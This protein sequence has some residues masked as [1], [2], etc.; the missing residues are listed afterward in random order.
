MARAKVGG[1]NWGAHASYAGSD[2]A[3]IGP[4]GAGLVALGWRPSSHGT[5][6][7][8]L[9]GSH[10]ACLAEVR[11]RFQSLTPNIRASILISVP[12]IPRL[13]G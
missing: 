12:R 9:R 7:V 10:P 3:F 6:F 5:G 2:T 8:T 13:T 1:R 11:V 4:S